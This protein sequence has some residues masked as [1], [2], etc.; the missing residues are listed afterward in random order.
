MRRLKLRYVKYFINISRLWIQTYSVI[1]QST[2]CMWFLWRFFPPSRLPCGCLS[3]IQRVSCVVWGRAGWRKGIK[4]VCTM[5]IT[6]INFRSEPGFGVCVH[7]TFIGKHNIWRGSCIQIRIYSLESDE[8]EVQ[9]RLVNEFWSG[10]IVP[11]RVK[12]VSWW[13]KTISDITIVYG[14]IKGHSV[15][16]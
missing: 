12:I 13:I 9:W 3:L 10:V 8:E 16:N 7:F 6:S 15:H 14:C 5:W 2:I 4:C 1:L 11:P